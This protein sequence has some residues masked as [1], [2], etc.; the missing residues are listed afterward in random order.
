MTTK[1]DLV[2]EA[3]AK[4]HT[5]QMQEIHSKFLFATF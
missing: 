5:M 2:K 3:S 1:R 4:A